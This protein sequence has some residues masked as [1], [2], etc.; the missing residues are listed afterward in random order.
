M[1]ATS[2]LVGDAYQRLK[3]EIRE[4][5][6]PPGF[7]ATEPEIAL[8]LGM[9]RTPVR[10]ALIRLAADGLIDMIPRRGVRVRPI[11]AEDM[12]EIYE[13][14]TAIEP[15][16]AAQLARR[17]LPDTD[18]APLAAATDRMEEAL[19][20]GDLEAWAAADDDF[21]CTLL[22]M[23]GN[24]R[25]LDMV[26]TLFDQAHR[27]RIVTLRLRALPERSTT[28]HRAILQAMARGHSDMVST[29]FRLHRERAAKELLDILETYRLPGL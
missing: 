4:N 2:K 18:L 5:R 22:E 29:L 10:E 13:I 27:A 24:R 25:M 8:R 6:L 7:Q 16:A 1:P 23:H 12:R 21:H 17:G 19:A 9:S 26:T 11:L 3:E 28:E 14:L 20:A 15:E